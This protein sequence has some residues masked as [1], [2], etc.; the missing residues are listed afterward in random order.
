MQVW[1]YK[2][3]S[4]NTIFWAIE[5]KTE[6]AVQSQDNEERLIILTRNGDYNDKR[7]ETEETEGTEERLKR[8][9]GLKTV[10]MIYEKSTKTT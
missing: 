4:S 5:N 2:G 9:K 8:L 3:S 6:N 10:T 1:Q 7:L